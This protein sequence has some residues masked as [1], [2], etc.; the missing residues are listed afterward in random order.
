MYEIY[1][2]VY[3]HLGAEKP[4]NFEITGTVT[5][6]DGFPYWNLKIDLGE[7]QDREYEEAK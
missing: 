4:N 6:R 3:D 5:V 2:L 7:Q 1:R